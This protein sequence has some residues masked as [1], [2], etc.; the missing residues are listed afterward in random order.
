MSQTAT[1]QAATELL[2]EVLPDVSTRR[3]FSDYLGPAV[4]FALT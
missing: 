4:V 2:N 3:R 1:P